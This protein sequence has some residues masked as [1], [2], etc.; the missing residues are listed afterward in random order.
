MLKM[1]AASIWRRKVVELPGSS[2][3]PSDSLR[4]GGRSKA[5]S[6]PITQRQ[7]VIAP[8]ASAAFVANMEDVL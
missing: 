3:A 6:S 5:F 7:W 4:S 8:E 1:D 2:G